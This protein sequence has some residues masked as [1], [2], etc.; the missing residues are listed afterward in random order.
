MRNIVKLI[1]L[2]YLS[3]KSQYTGGYEMLKDTDSAYYDIECYASGEPV[4]YCKEKCD[5]SNKC[6]G[7]IYVHSD[8][9]YG[10]WWGKSGCCYKYKMY[11]LVEKKGVDA[12][13]KVNTTSEKEESTSIEGYKMYKDM[14]SAKFDIECYANGESMNVCKEKCDNV[15]NCVGYIYVHSD[16]GYGVWWGKSGCCY[17][18]DLSELVAKKGVDTYVKVNTTA[19]ET[20]TTETEISVN[21]D[22]KSILE[23]L[24]ILLK[25][26]EKRVE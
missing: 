21:S 12:Y 5:A 6:M 9:G 10:V 16:T 1:T 7:Y 4:N 23:E 13:V 8:T 2:M 17:K 26:L 11:N 14:D 18:Y 22:I 24:L 15:S 20:M 25:E 19:T 3:T